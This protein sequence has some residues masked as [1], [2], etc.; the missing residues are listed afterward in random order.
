ML[1]A[2][3]AERLVE[4]DVGFGLNAFNEGVNFKPG[5]SKIDLESVF[6]EQLKTSVRKE[7]ANESSMKTDGMFGDRLNAYSQQHMHAK[8]MQ[9]QKQPQHKTLKRRHMVFRHERQHIQTD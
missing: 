1:L 4:G 2:D 7:A 9:Q 3:L 6:K 5:W 8:L